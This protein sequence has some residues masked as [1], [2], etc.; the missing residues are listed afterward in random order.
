MFG[1]SKGTIRGCWSNPRVDTLRFLACVLFKRDEFASFVESRLIHVQ[2]RVPEVRDMYFSPRSGRFHIA[3]ENGP[4]E[5]SVH[6][7]PAGLAFEFGAESL[8]SDSENKLANWLA[9]F[10]RVLFGDI[11]ITVP[12]IDWSVQLACG[13][14]A[15]FD[16]ERVDWVVQLQ[17][18]GWELDSDIES[19][20]VMGGKSRI[21][22]QSRQRRVGAKR[23]I[24]ET[25]RAIAYEAVDLDGIPYVR[26]EVSERVG[27]RELPG[28]EVG[29]YLTPTSYR[30]LAWAVAKTASPGGQWLVGDPVFAPPMPRDPSV[31]VRQALTL[32]AGALAPEKV[33]LLLELAVDE[34]LLA[35]SDVAPAVERANCRALQQGSARVRY[36]T[37]GVS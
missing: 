31:Q 26:F 2:Q 6:F 7:T 17:T 19:H 4:I 1:F 37:V 24:M 34:K 33:Q 8:R 20:G 13:S 25:Y 35:D 23:V 29:L 27:S 11:R 32:L 18:M 28:D 3:A 22:K 15:A 10:S 30:A 9:R 36:F 12:R 14:L 5:A 21:W 16:A